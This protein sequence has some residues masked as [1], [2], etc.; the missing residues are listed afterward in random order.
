MN[1]R[2]ACL[3]IMLIF[4]SCSATREGMPRIYP[5]AMSRLLS[6]FWPQ[7]WGFFTKSPREEVIAVYQKEGND[8]RQ[9]DLRYSTGDGFMTGSRRHRFL[10][11][12]AG[13][14]LSKVKN[15]R[16]MKC[17][18]KSTCLQAIDQN[19][20][21]THIQNQTN[22]QQICGMIAIKKYRFHPYAWAKNLDGQDPPGMVA[23][24]DVECE[25]ST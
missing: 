5:K 21:P 1:A 15:D 20:N 4:V 24:A 25:E 10:A 2:M 18:S 23:I 22:S 11:R 17:S 9:I 14:I 7:N 19:S 6:V 16:W 3:C 13:W 8:W 12:E